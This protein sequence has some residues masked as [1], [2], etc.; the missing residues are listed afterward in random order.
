MKA[1]CMYSY[2]PE[3][4]LHCVRTLCERGAGVNVKD[5]MGWTAVLTAAR[6][7]NAVYIPI[8]LG[9]GASLTDTTSDQ[10]NILHIDAEYGEGE[11]IEKVM[12]SHPEII[13]SLANARNVLGETPLMVAQRCEKD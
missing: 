6:Y 1:V 10:E 12:Q 7:G 8:L 2:S 5:E 3:Y 11:I 9:H 13:R 4:Y